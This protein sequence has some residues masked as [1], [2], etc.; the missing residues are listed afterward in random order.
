MITEPALLV[1]VI[2]LLLAE[3]VVFITGLATFGSNI[4]PSVAPLTT[5]FLDGEVVLKFGS[6]Q[7]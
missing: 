7:F 4:M 3:V 6:N 5:S 1:I 2:L